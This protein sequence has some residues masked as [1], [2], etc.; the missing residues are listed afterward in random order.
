MLYDNL[1]CLK[2]ISPQI[3]YVQYYVQYYEILEK[4]ADC[5]AL[6]ATLSCVVAMSVVVMFVVNMSVLKQN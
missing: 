4:D 6:Y 2:Y 3:F 1:W 5:S